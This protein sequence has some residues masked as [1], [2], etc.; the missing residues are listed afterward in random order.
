VV[1]DRAAVVRAATPR[2]RDRGRFRARDRHRPRAA[3]CRRASWRG[4]RTIP[5]SVTTAC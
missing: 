4:C 2:A 1:D 5:S 3:G